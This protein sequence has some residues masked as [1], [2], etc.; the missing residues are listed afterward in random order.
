MAVSVAD[1]TSI[2]TQHRLSGTVTGTSRP[3]L[4]VFIVAFNAA[5]TIN[6]V[7]SR[8]PAS[9]CE[10]YEVEVLVIDDAS[11]DETFERVRDNLQALDL[12]FPLTLLFNP[13]NQGYG[14]NQKIGYLY[15]IKKSGLAPL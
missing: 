10:K 1:S 4:L 5:R 3:R 6:S 9:I 14:G 15:A 2:L 13:K 12:A 7:L 11:S 8:I